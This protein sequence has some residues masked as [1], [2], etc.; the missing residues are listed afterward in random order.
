MTTHLTTNTTTNTTNTHT[1]YDTKGNAIK[2]SQ[3]TTSK[4]DTK[5]ETTHESKKSI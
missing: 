2:Q 1:I 4:Q 5:T 3:S